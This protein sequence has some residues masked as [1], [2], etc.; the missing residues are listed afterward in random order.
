MY[1]WWDH[2]LRFRNE[3]SGGPFARPSRRHNRHRVPL[4][5]SSTHECIRRLLCLHLGCQALP[6]KAAEHLPQTLLQHVLGV[7]QGR[8]EHCVAYFGLEGLRDDRHKEIPASQG[9]TAS[10][11]GVQKLRAE[12]RVLSE[13]TTEHLRG[14]VLRHQRILLQPFFWEIQDRQGHQWQDLQRNAQRLEGRTV[15]DAS[16]PTEWAIPRGTQRRKGSLLRL[17][18]R[19]TWLLEDLGS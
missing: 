18:R 9:P 1:Q 14:W 7:Q 4:T 17:H 10:D 2:H 3:Q 6:V 15:C 13:A 11:P 5:I 16:R 19:W 8:K 12:L